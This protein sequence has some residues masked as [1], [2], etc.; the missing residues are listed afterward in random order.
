MVPVLAVVAC[1]PRPP[2]PVI[3]EAIELVQR[4]PPYGVPHAL[5]AINDDVLVVGDDG[6]IAS[7][8][9]CGNTWTRVRH[10]SER[11]RAIAGSARL[12][13]AAGEDGAVVT[14]TPDAGWRREAS[15]VDE[16]FVAV[17]V[18]DS[19]AIAVTLDGTLVRRNE[20]GWQRLPDVLGGH[21]GPL[22]VAS[23]VDV[24]WAGVSVDG[25][26]IV[27]R[28][29][30]EGPPQRLPSLPTVSGLATHDGVLYASTDERWFLT[31]AAWGCKAC[32]PL[33][34]ARTGIWRYGSG[35]WQP[36]SP[37]PHRPLPDPRTVANRRCAQKLG[38]RA[39]RP[40][41]TA[42]ACPWEPE[43]WRWTK[44]EGWWTDSGDLSLRGD[45]LVSGSGVVVDLVSGTVDQMTPLQPQ[46]Q[47]RTAIVSCGGADRL[48]L[49][50]RAAGQMAVRRSTNG[51]KDWVAVPWWF[52]NET[53]PGSAQVRPIGIVDVRQGVHDDEILVGAWSGAVMRRRGAGP[54]TPEPRSGAYVAGSRLGEDGHWL[55]LEGGP[56]RIV[57]GWAVRSGRFFGLDPDRGLFETHNGGRTWTSIASPDAFW[58]PVELP[59][60]PEGPPIHSRRLA[61]VGM[62]ELDGVPYALVRQAVVRLRRGTWQRYAS[63]APPKG[64]ATAS[65]SHDGHGS[66]Y[67]IDGQLVVV[68]KGRIVR[69]RRGRVVASH[70]VGQV[71]RSTM[72]RDG[73]LW[74][75]EP[76]TLRLTT[77][78]GQTWV[79]HPFPSGFAPR[80][81]AAVGPHLVVADTAGLV[82]FEGRV[83]NR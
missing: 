32:F 64:V 11:L 68:Q 60:G 21:A 7:T 52:G 4:E 38:Q 83:R 31:G 19:R 67:A 56:G 6:W 80:H 78:L 44:H 36:F 35:S 59:G 26:G 9:D 25:K 58:D 54:W 57:E 29:P 51:G 47:R 37:R 73:W 12:V 69:L 27:W 71:L 13:V 20:V 16:W 46:D 62:T 74:I 33:G 22:V 15:G 8:A 43:R 55:S 66:L 48:A 81:V 17:A 72:S 23:G 28:L 79:E 34:W 5:A 61:I 1:S 3:P 41:P 30:V 70:P 77:D 49:L 10:G 14:W 2:P 42:P 24:D 50:P 76:T 65:P 39:R 40:R 45:E 75:I 18:H 63:L 82:V 53:V